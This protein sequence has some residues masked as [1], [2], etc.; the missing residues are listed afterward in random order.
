MNDYKICVYAICKNEEKFVDR[1]YNSVQEADYIVVLDTGSTDNTVQKL[2]EKKKVIVRQKHYDFFRFD[3]A[4]ND[5]MKLIPKDTDICV[6]TDL[7][8]VFQ[9]GWS[10]LLRNKWNN[11]TTKAQITFIWNFKEDGKPGVTFNYEKIH[12]PNQYKWIHAV[13]EILQRTVDTPEI[14]TYIPEL[15]L[16]HHADPLK[17]RS[18]YLSLLELDVQERPEDDRARHYYGR[19]LMFW[20]KNEQ[21]I[22][23]FK[24][25]LNL[26][27]ATWEP[28]RSA[29]MRY[30][31]KCST[32]IQE[33]E[34]WLFRAI[35]ET[36]YLREPW[37]DMALLQYKQENWD[38]VIYFCDQGLKI[39]NNLK[40]YTND[41]IAWHEGFYDLL[42]IAY[43]NK[44]EY[45]Q[46]YINIYI[47][48]EEN[49]KDLRLQ[50]NK[51]LIKKFLNSKL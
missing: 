23:Q 49:T 2:Q 12:A 37:Y 45:N 22:E 5:S 36:P 47:A 1:W 17:S 41:P 31:A 30:I 15:I 28:E 35:A 13:H 14:K 9:K 6:C 24:I 46:A 21:A 33:K 25:H 43:F 51:E 27:S 8:E 18:N 48:C 19:E 29:S 34:K 3:V 26:P 38:G 32:N 7:D 50:K 4:R 10:T 16:E 44:K 39:K 20:N 42:S 40:I 11:N